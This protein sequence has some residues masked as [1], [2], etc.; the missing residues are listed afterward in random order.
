MSGCAPL[1]SNQR[2]KVATKPAT[3]LWSRPGGHRQF[4]GHAV[5]HSVFPF[6][7]RFTATLYPRRFTSLIFVASPT[8]Q[9]YITKQMV[10]R[11]IHLR[12]F[13][14]EVICRGYKVLMFVSFSVAFFALVCH[15]PTLAC[16]AP[17]VGRRFGRK[18]ARRRRYNG[19]TAANDPGRFNSRFFHDHKISAPHR[20]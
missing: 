9:K 16:P 20:V 7:H 12:H 3:H 15:V 11:R 10:L 1:V 8:G 4:R 5:V 14:G 2:T 17:Q 6:R 18:V 19:A 13:M